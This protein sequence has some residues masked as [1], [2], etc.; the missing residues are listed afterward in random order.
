MLKN[1]I[2]RI[3]L[4]FTVLAATVACSGK[5]EEPDPNALDI[6]GIELPSVIEAKSGAEIAVTDRNGNIRTSDVV[7]FNSVTEN[8]GFDCAV[9]K[10]DSK[11]FTFKLNPKINSG[12]YIC[13]IKRGLSDKTVGVTNIKILSATEVDPGDGT[14]YGTVTCEG[15]AIKDVV[16]SDGVEVVT[17]DKDGI[18]RINSGKATGYVFISIPSGYAVPTKGILPIFHHILEKGAGEPER[19]D[20]TL[21]RTSNEKHTVLVMG[22]IHLANRNNDRVEFKKFTTDVM[23]YKEEHPGEVIYGL[24]LGDMTWDAYW[25]TNNYY[26]PNYLSDMNSVV[27]GIPV[28]HTIGNHDH[29]MKAAGDILTIVDYVKDIAPNYY[30]FNLGKVHYIVLDDILCTNDGSGTSDSRKYSEKI[31]DAQYAWLKKDLQFVDK[32]TPVVVS[33]HAPIFRDN[34][35]TYGIT[36]HAGLTGWSTLVNCFTG[37]KTVHFL[38]G[39]THRSLNVDRTSTSNYFE[40]NA[41]AVCA[42]WWWSQKCSTGFDVCTDGTPGGYLVWKVDGTDFKWQYKGTK[43]NLD[44]QFRSYDLNNVCF[45]ASMVNTWVPEGSDWAKNRFVELYASRFPKSSANEILLNIWD[46]DPSWTIKLVEKTSSGDKELTWS[47]VQTLDPLHIICLSAKR[48]NSSSVTSDPSFLTNLSSH[49]FKAKAS[50]PGTTIEITVTDRFGNVYR[51]TMT[52]PKTFSL[53]SYKT[54]YAK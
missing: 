45:D 26:F 48:L 28:F 37:Y 39:H 36:P 33:M 38:T 9:V 44:Y 3:I 53:G 35:S 43:E 42:S 16:V 4:I 47:Q 6:S 2:E 1:K 25:Y 54:G 12:R 20:F 49:L 51:E 30:S 14:I 52:R 24:T 31:T 32:N 46:Y 23:K 22:D 15:A 13:H 11:S 41:G 8:G 34:S 17:T 5:K 18:Y 10:T 50:A 7:V 40:H 21:T 27:S 29:D 19:V